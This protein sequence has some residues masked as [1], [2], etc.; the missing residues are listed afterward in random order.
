[1]ARHPAPGRVKTRLAAVIGADRACALHRSFVLDLA[2]RL[3][4]T[5]YRVTW[6]FEPPE[7]PFATLLPGRRCRPQ[8]AGDLGA[9]MARAI[10]DEFSD[11]RGP[12]VVLG[13][14]VPHVPL[15]R[16]GDA[17]AALTSDADVVLGP[18]EDG[19][20]YLIGLAAPAPA[21]FAGIA[22]GTSDVLRATTER[23]AA[24]RLR[25]RLVDATFDVD[26]VADLDRLRR[27]LDDGDVALPRTAAVLA[28]IPRRA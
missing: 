2:D 7:A 15:R 1:M 9:R 22:W 26:E 18:A 23:A 3:D 13:A 8:S 25:T 6:T 5:P 14:D 24:A 11:G 19:G 4:D 12:V 28:D 17:F 16:L 10:A 20:Y 21:L 27:L